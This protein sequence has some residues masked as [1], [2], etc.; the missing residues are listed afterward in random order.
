MQL[1]GAFRS[2]GDVSIA[3]SSTGNSAN[4][5]HAVQVAREMG[6]VTVGFL[7]RTGGQLK[8]MVDVAGLVPS[9]DYG[10]IED[11]HIVFDHL[12]TAYF[13]QWLAAKAG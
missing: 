13:K 10:P 3:I 8:D 7:G 12:L 4:V 9:D 11:V 1:L 6:L 2:S 5:V